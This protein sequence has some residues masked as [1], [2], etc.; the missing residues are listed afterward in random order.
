MLYLPEPSQSPNLSY[1]H[2]SRHYLHAIY[3][4]ASVTHQTSHLITQVDI[5]YMPYIPVPQSP[6]LSHYHTSTHISHDIFTCA[7][8]THQTFHII[9]QVHMPHMPYLPVPQSLTKPLT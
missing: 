8:V 9:T 3:T 1:D 5:T 2:T 6:N 7:Q 4:C